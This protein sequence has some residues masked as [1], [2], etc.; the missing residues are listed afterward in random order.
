MKSPLG[1]L[2]LV[3]ATLKYANFAAFLFL[4]NNFTI[5]SVPFDSPLHSMLISL[6]KI[7]VAILE[8]I[9]EN[10][11]VCVNLRH[12]CRKFSRPE[13]VNFLVMEKYF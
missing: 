10:L 11:A 2:G 8:V 5:K 6:F 3:E 13:R 12:I 1:P 9:L 7:V 4:F